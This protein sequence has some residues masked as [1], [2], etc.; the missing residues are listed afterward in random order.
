MMFIIG[1][2]MT[3]SRLPPI[4]RARCRY[5]GTLRIVRGRVGGGQG[6][7]RI[8]LAPRLPLLSVPSSSIILRIEAGLIL[9]IEAQQRLLQH[10]VDVLDRLST[11]LPP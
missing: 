6:D 5:S 11:P 4:R 10:G 3:G 9:R 2:G 1:T 7:A 8:A